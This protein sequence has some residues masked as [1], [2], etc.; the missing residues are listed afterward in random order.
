VAD[1]RIDVVTEGEYIT[2]GSRVRVVRTDG[3]RHI[4]RAA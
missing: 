4:V 1:E 2:I 3:Y